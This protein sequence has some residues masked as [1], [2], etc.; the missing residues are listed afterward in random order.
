VQVLT[1]DYTSRDLPEIFARSV[2]DTGFAFLVNA[3]LDG[4]ALARFYEAW[5]A[6]FADARKHDCASDPDLP[7][8]YLPY[9]SP[10]GRLIDLKESFY[11]HRDRLCPESARGITEEVHRSLLGLA[12]EL[13]DGLVCSEE[14]RIAPVLRSRLLGTPRTGTLRIIHYP[15]L[16][17]LREWH[18][19]LAGASE[20]PIR[21]AAHQD[22]NLLTV[23]PAATRPGLDLMDTHGGW[24]RVACDTGAVVVNAGDQLQRL[25]GGYYRSTRHRVRNSIAELGQPRYSAALFLA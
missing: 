20:D 24:H 4:C 5:A 18:D 23:L 9:R 12:E 25:S 3:P 19:R 1:A 10:D 16:S 14:A 17:Q 11:Y 21:L 13:L 22:L 15:A 8:G 7:A 6:F 2:R